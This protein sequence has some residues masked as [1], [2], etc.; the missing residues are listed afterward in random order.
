MTT[1]KETELVEAIRNEYQSS[2]Y[3]IG[4]RLK[5]LEDWRDERMRWEENEKVRREDISKRLEAV[6]DDI[7]L[8]KKGKNDAY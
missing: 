6:Q 4:D 3:I 1:F 2:I 5:G 8:L 7:V